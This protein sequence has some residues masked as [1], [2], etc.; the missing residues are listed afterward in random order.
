MDALLQI[1]PHMYSHLRRNK[2]LYIHMSDLS[3]CGVK[4]PHGW[5]TKGRLN[6][7]EAHG[8]RLAVLPGI[9]IWH[10]N[11]F[12]FSLLITV[13]GEVLVVSRKANWVVLWHS[14][15]LDT[16]QG[17]RTGPG[18]PEG[19]SHDARTTSFFTLWSI[20]LFWGETAPALVKKKLV[21]EMKGRSGSWS[22][23][24]LNSGLYTS[25]HLA[26]YLHVPTYIH[27]SLS[28]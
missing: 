18:G 7:M 6:K 1:C 2:Y 24:P 8:N 27:I 19:A 5:P 4:T 20:S 28:A 11:H 26:T 16:S 17:L 14:V 15:W 12:F 13:A 25:M 23:E 22:C 21:M 3:M 10:F 9:E